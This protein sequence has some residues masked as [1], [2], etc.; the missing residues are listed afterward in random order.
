LR[1][2]RVG[3]RVLPE[4]Q[5]PSSRISRC[6]V[7]R[8]ELGRNQPPLR[9]VQIRQAGTSF[10]RKITRVGR[11]LLSDKCGAGALARLFSFLCELCGSSLRPLRLRA[12]DRKGRK[13]P[14][15]DAKKIAA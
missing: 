12:F 1:Q 11:T 5:Q 15:K 14:A 6:L 4:V 3:A 13:V 7:E 9:D 10:G 8:G 2:R